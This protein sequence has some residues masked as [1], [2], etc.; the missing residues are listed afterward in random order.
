[1]YFWSL[2]INQTSRELNKAKQINSAHLR[3]YFFREKC[4]ASGG[5]R[6]HD[7][8][9]SRLST[10]PTKLLRQLSQHGPNFLHKY[11]VRQGKS[12]QPDEQVSQ[13]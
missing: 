4:A 2:M 10:L 1:M 5:I 8:L 9:L 11:K 3:K 7:T 12:S 13:T 6:T